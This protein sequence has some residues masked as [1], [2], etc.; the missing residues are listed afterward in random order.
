MKKFRYDSLLKYRVFVEESKM[1][2]LAEVTQKLNTEE[3]R[4]F[5]LEEIRRQAY[6]ELTEKQERNLAPHELVLYQMYLQQIKVEIE[7]QQKKVSETQA[8]YDEKKESL[9]I[10]TQEKKIIEKVKSK[11]KAI[12][13]DVE[14]RAEKKALDETGNIRYVRENC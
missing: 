3:K 11:D 8:L 5:T 12:L 2:E 6:E 13:R 9:I 1:S 10:A 4:L 14:K 7:T